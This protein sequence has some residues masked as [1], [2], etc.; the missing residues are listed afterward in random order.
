M[1]RHWRWIRSASWS[2]RTAAARQVFAYVPEIPAMYEA[3]TVREH[4]EFVLQA[5]Q[6]RAAEGEVE[7]LGAIWYLYKTTLKNRVR[8]A[9]RRPVTYLYVALVL[10]YAFCLPF[11][12]Q[13]LLQEFCCMHI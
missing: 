2:G 7:E 13:V 4:I 11:S 8:K 3:L 10:I 9:V 6:R 1:E 12:F 5:Y